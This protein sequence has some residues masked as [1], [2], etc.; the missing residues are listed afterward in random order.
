MN[1]E[2]MFERPASCLS[3]QGKKGVYVIRCNGLGRLPQLGCNPLHQ[4]DR[5]VG[6]IIAII[7]SRIRTETGDAELE[8][9]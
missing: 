6:A 9:S 4:D 2:E 7:H 1:E 8:R 5:P 3:K